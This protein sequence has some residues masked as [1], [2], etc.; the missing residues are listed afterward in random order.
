MSAAGSSL[1][2]GLRFGVVTVVSAT[3]L[4]NRLFFEVFGSI[5]VFVGRRNCLEIIVG[6]RAP[7]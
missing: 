1:L 7:L 3:M 4:W 5:R 2:L 6:N